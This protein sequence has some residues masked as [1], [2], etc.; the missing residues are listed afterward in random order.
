MK[1][2]TLII[3]GPYLTHKSHSAPYRLSTSDGLDATIIH[4]FI[5]SLNYMRK[6]FNPEKIFITWESHGTDSWR[7]KEYPDYKS[8][9]TPIARMYI[10]EIKDL[11]ILL[12]LFGV[13]QYYSPRNEADDVIARLTT[14]EIKPILIHTTDKDIM[15]L[16]ND[17]VHIWTGKEIFDSEK[18]NEKYGVYPKYIPDLLA[19]AGD[20]ADNIKGIDGVGFKKASKMIN[21]EGMIEQMGFSS[22]LSN[23]TYSIDIRNR[24][25]KNKRLTQLNY[26]CNLL[27]IP[28][29]DFK[30]EFTIETL[31]DKY[32]LKKMKEK[33]EEYKLMGEDNGN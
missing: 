10:D 7:K 22:C 32:N 21:K 23:I 33:I 19:L 8:S 9:T 18:V 15:Q 17:Y 31:M 6:K 16:V 28:H 24:V 1:Y 30:T 27:E 13:K 12:H 3:D 25:I 26:N 20:K 5:R 29:P 2:K 14:L 4:S 11:Q